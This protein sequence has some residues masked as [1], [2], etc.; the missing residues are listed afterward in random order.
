MKYRCRWLDVLKG[1]GIIFVVV[2]HF[3]DN[4]RIYHWIYSFHM[5]L[6]FFAS[7]FLY[8]RKP[9]ILTIKHKFMTL[10]VPYFIFGLISQLFYAINELS[11]ARE[12]MAVDLLAGLLYGTYSSIIY[13]KV[14]NFP[15]TNYRTLPE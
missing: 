15:S 13:N 4:D 10:M 12:V 8:H 1:F 14:L 3:C 11:H 9:I 5:P 7:G 6:F 2:G